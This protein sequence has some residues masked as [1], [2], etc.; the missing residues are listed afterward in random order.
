ML[1]STD[2]S[3]RRVRILHVAATLPVLFFLSSQIVSELALLESTMQWVPLVHEFF[4]THSV[5][6]SV[7][8]HFERTE[9]ILFV[10]S[11]IFRQDF[12]VSDA[13]NSRKDGEKSAHS[14]PCGRTKK[15]L[16]S[17]CISL[18]EEVHAS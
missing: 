2:S 15:W 1:L 5:T 3:L 12:D 13:F 7:C 8:I 9:Q 10:T 14:W 6:S 18:S 17:Q 4:V 16:L 11:D